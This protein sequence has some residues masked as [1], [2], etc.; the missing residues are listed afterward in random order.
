MTATIHATFT[1]ASTPP[2]PVVSRPPTAAAAVT[3][4]AGRGIRDEVSISEEARRLFAEDAPGDEETAAG[5]RELSADEQREVEELKTRDREVRAHEQAHVAALGGEGGSAKLSYTTGPDG[6]QYATDGE[7][8][9]SISEVAGNPQATIQR[10]RKIAA[11]ALAPAQPSGADVKAAA[12]ARQLEARARRDLAE[13]TEEADVPG[14]HRDDHE[15]APGET[16][17]ICGT[18]RLTRA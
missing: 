2:A 9:I 13:K 7:V 5:P 4:A 17:E 15:H 11:A 1:A 14:P 18:G 12:K 6:R 16:C 3:S 8:P 10:A